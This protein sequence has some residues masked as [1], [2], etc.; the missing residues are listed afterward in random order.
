VR[1]GHWADNY[2]ARV[3]GLLHP[4]KTGDYTFWIAAD[5]VGELWLSPTEGPERKA[6]LCYTAEY[7]SPREWTKHPQ[8]RSRT[9]HLVAGR[10][11]YIEA[12]MKESAG[13]DCLA[14]AWQAP[15]LPQQVIPGQHLSP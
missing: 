9:I 2:G 14:V 3:R 15:G 7:T 6:R 1:N 11:Y 8:Q 12:L 5:D 10:R 13:G 4:P